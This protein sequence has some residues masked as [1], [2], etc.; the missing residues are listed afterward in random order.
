[1]Q[2]QIILNVLGNIF[3]FRKESYVRRFLE[4]AYLVTI[5]QR[6]SKKVSYTTWDYVIRSNSGE[7]KYTRDVKKITIS[8]FAFLPVQLGYS[9]W[10]GELQEGVAKKS[11]WIFYREEKQILLDTPYRH[12]ISNKKDVWISRK[13]I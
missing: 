1:M 3:T 2:R 9:I 10:N 5:F 12:G 11:W 4:W 8:K 7:E 6:K 13:Q